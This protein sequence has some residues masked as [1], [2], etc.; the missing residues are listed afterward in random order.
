MF[1]VLM[2][3]FML[4]SFGKGNVH[5]YENADY[6]CTYQTQEGRFHGKYVSFYTNGKKKVEG[7]FKQNI[8]DGIWTMWDEKGSIILKRNY[9]GPYSYI[10]TIG[11]DNKSK[12]VSYD[13]IR[14]SLGCYK[15]YQILEVE[16]VLMAFRLRRIIEPKNNP[17]MFNENRLF[18]AIK[19]AHLQDSVQVYPNDSLLK[20]IQLDVSSLNQL[21][22][23]GFKTMEDF[24]IDKDRMASEFY[25]IAICPLVRKINTNDTLEMGW[26]KMD[27]L[28]EYLVQV[29]TYG[30]KQ[31]PLV[32]NMDDL[33]YLH[34][35]F[36]RVVHQYAFETDNSIR[37][38]HPD[39]ENISHR[40]DL[41][42]IDN[43]HNFW[44]HYFNPNK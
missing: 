19:N 3:I 2:T 27:D 16:K 36:G 23:I 42:V 17:V 34:S 33:F 18:I 9:V 1:P 14:D 40:I 22:C 38:K 43:E 39:K 44:Y 8:R 30:L 11:S 20:P 12:S 13:L 4:F 26:F 21:E 25:T 6:L 5:F 10:E 15:H 35:F 7:Y 41:D 28:R 31:M 37:T 29:K 24:F 32:E